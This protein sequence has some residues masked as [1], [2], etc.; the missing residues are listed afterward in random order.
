MKTI[1]TVAALVLAA[2]LVSVTSQAQAGVR[3]F[4]DAGGTCFVCQR[5]LPT[6]EIAYALSRATTPPSATPNMNAILPRSPAPSPGRL[7]PER[8]AYGEVPPPVPMPPPVPK[9]PPGRVAA[10]PS[11]NTMPPPMH[12]PLSRD[13][14]RENVIR[15]GEAFCAKYPDDKVCHPLT[16]APPPQ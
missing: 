1:T 7:Y 2:S 13:E 16:E 14:E 6:C 11:Q 5:G 10:P 8:D 4:C 12:S 9:S 15:Q 3:Q